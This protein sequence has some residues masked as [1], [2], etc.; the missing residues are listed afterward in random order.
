MRF[1]AVWKFPRR[2]FP[3]RT[4]GHGKSGNGKF[5]RR[6]YNFLSFFPPL[7]FPPMPSY[8]AF[9]QCIVI[10]LRI[11]E[12]L[13]PARKTYRERVGGYRE[14]GHYRDANESIRYTSVVSRRTLPVTRGIILRR[15]I[16]RTSI[17]RPREIGALDA[18]EYSN[19]AGNA[20]CAAARE[21]VKPCETAPSLPPSP[22]V[23]AET[24]EIG[25]KF[26]NTCGRAD[27]SGLG[28]NRR[29]PACDIAEVARTIDI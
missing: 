17:G 1:V 19:G 29:P 8:C 9:T 16:P 13:T 6:G 7:F 21:S 12:K 2:L 18:T 15:P 25:T 10:R 3:R 11:D 24:E 28:G 14:R 23:R 26:R 4:D 22:L 27:E 20:R 5:F